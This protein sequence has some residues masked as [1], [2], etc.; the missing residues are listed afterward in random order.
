MHHLQGIF[1]LDDVN[2]RQRPPRSSNRVEGPAAAGLELG[3]FRNIVLD[4]AL[5][6]LQR[7]VRRILQREASQRQRHAL[8]NAV[9]AHVDQFQRP[10]AEIADN[11]VRPVQAGNNAQRG[12][13]SFARPRKNFDWHAADAFGL[14]DEVRTVAGV[15][16]GRGG[17][18]VDAA[19]LH[20]P[21]QR[22]KP[23]QRRQ[24]LDDGIGRQQAGGLHLAAEPA[25]GF[26]VED[27]Y[28]AALH[29]FV[30]D[31]THRIGADV[32]DRDAGCAFARP[33]HRAE[34]LMTTADARYGA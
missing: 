31:E 18:G 15:A 29:R 33:L 1:T 24:R 28:Q 32:D 19:D 23:P 6:A 7:L 21:A 30:D 25:Q 12:E 16:A 8:T 9:A 34:S 2:A 4:D 27:R 14:G 5:G 22:A 13:F 17:D 26:L 10:A 11:A 3:D 20:H